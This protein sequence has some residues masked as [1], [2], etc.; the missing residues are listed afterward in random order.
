MLPRIAEER[1][2]CLG[3]GIRGGVFVPEVGR[4]DPIRLQ[5]TLLYFRNNSALK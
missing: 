3:L 5:L 2:E 4:A 1:N